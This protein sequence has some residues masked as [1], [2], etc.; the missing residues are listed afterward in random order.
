MKEV[1][2]AKMELDL[3][4]VVEAGESTDV[5][6]VKRI[7]DMEE[8]AFVCGSVTERRKVFVFHPFIHAVT[9]GGGE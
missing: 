5:P 9:E 6:L 7:A 4:I 1:W 2:R 8:V 3:V